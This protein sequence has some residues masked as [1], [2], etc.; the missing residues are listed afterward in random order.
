MATSIGDQRLKTRVQNGQ[1]DDL[2]AELLWDNPDGLRPTPISPRGRT[3]DPAATTWTLQPV[4]Q[5]RGVAVFT[6]DVGNDFPDQEMRRRIARELQKTA[7]EHLIIFHTNDFSQ[8]KWFWPYREPG[9][10]TRPKEVG[11][12]SCENAS[13]LLNLLREI[14]FD[15][16]SE[17]TL[18][19]TDVTD[20]LNRAASPDK[21]TR[22]FY[23]EFSQQRIA[24][25]KFIEGV[26][27]EADRDWYAAIM[28]N[29][30]MFTWFLQSKGF[31]DGDRNYLSNRL[32][33][34]Q[35]G[36]LPGLTFHEF[37]KGFLRTLFHDGLNNP[38]RND[39]LRAQLGDVPYI[40]GG[41]F[42]QHALETANPEIE[43]PND[44]F[45]KLFAFF[46]QY[47]WHL[48]DRPLGNENEINPDVLGYIFEKFVNQKE[49]G[50][51]YTKEDVTGYI[52]QNTIIP[53]LLNKVRKDCRGAFDITQPGNAWELLK[54]T[55]T[56]YIYPSMKH[57]VIDE[58]NEV[59]SMPDA[60]VA[61]EHDYAQRQTWNQRAAEPYAL[62][63]ETWREYFHR[64]RRTLA[65]REKLANG[66]IHEVD[67]LITW[68][69]DIRQFAQDVVVNIGVVDLIRAYW[70]AIADITILDPTVGSGAFLFAAVRVVEPLYTGLLERMELA[71]VAEPGPRTKDF[72]DTLTEARTHPNRDYFVMR[73]I[74]LNNLY[75]VDI[76]EEA[77][78]ICNLRLFLLLAA[79][80]E[81]GKPIEPLPDID[82]NIRAGNTLVGYATESDVEK[83]AGGGQLTLAAGDPFTPMNEAVAQAD[84]AF[85]HFQRTQGDDRDGRADLP[86]AKA[87]YLA[88][89]TELRD[90]LDRYL[91]AQQR[92]TDRFEAWRKRTQP[93]H[94]FA[95]FHSI[96]IGN[97]GFDVIIANPPYVK[98]S[99]I[100]TQYEIKGFKTDDCPNI[101]AM[102]MERCTTLVS[103]SSSMGLIVPLSLS[104]AAKF[105]PIRRIIQR[106]R[107]SWFSSFDILPASLFTGVA[108]RCT[109]YIGRASHQPFFTRTTR[110]HR[111]RSA[112]RPALMQGVE[113]SAFQANLE[114]GSELPRHA[115]P[116]SVDLLRKIENQ[117][118]TNQTRFAMGLRNGD[119]EIRFAKAALNFVSVFIENPPTL[120]SPNLRP[121]SS[122]SVGSQA[123]PS[124]YASDPALAVL[125][126]ELFMWNWWTNGD[127]FHLTNG[128][129]SD[130]LVTLNG[131][132]NDHYIHIQNLGKLLW[133]RRNEVLVFKHHAKQYIGNYN[134]RSLHR[135]TRRSDLLVMNGIGL[136]TESA[137]DILDFAQRTLLVN[138]L[139][140]E[141]GIPESLRQMFPR[142]R[143]QQ[144]VLQQESVLA[145]VDRFICSATGLSPS[146][147]DCVL[148]TG[149]PQWPSLP[150]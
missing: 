140:G 45:G 128:D 137:L 150:D 44:A 99:D 74:I 79:K 119:G 103:A 56:K 22:R 98:A 29:R 61:G 13:H 37:Y 109:I 116:L 66:E 59:I 87:G 90:K 82:F 106:Q 94:W 85:Q 62:P 83:A 144:M 54:D 72:G 46:G 123:L 139:A 86:N 91:F 58:R 108:Q 10:P 7:H 84:R 64:R 100:R 120:T 76:E 101:Y 21:V 16:A 25:V 104:F 147:L 129:V 14:T 78:E 143:D 47:T 80:L 67:D 136:S 28:L 30:L 114:S 12:T 68:N 39:T 41:I 96:V 138:E 148:E 105:A 115:S 110:L 81:E 57:G 135:I 145:D 60:L 27:G 18:V 38:E 93:F 142:G 23:D 112:N 133:E 4:C 71:V 73:Q 50:A 124:S 35:Q 122:E 97:G 107:S 75:G 102:V 5:K 1:F 34:I 9:K 126:G 40:N 33:M 31:L 70:K 125:A 127:G 111:W 69:L 24:F 141:K 52:S 17:G 65:L 49:K 55:P 3:D 134:H 36:K 43:I 146:E 88:R 15:F 63:T 8:Q 130:F 11:F 132:S 131:V 117:P 19:L 121:K 48:D 118:K 32:A 149:Y 20:R 2:F 95:E 6:R 89:I 113:Y 51:Y 77:V 92:P 42:E 26:T 53:W